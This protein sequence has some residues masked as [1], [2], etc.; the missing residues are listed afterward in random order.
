M[1]RFWATLRKLKSE[2]ASVMVEQKPDLLRFG[3]QAGD[4]NSSRMEIFG[5]CV[6]KGG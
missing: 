3:I 4:V 5:L 6:E 2:I 1:A